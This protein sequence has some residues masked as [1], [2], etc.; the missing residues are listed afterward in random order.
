M[1]AGHQGRL[2]FSHKLTSTST[3]STR[4]PCGGRLEYLHYSF[5]NCKR[6]CKGNPVPRGIT[7]PPY[8][9]GI[10]IW[11]PGPPGWGSLRWESN[12]WLCVLHDSNPWVISLHTTDPS[13]HQRGCPT[14]RNKKL[15]DYRKFKVWSWASDGGPTQKWTGWLTVGRKKSW[16]WTWSI[17]STKSSNLEDVTNEK[18]KVG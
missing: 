8:S 5:A 7:G 14:R 10:Y 3:S 13:S 18:Y 2:T 1:G 6:R 11:E 4:S 12:I 9:W 15:S 17:R 16:I